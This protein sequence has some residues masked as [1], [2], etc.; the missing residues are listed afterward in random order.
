LRPSVE[1]TTQAK[2]DANHPEGLVQDPQRLTLAQEERRWAREQ[3]LEHISSQAMLTDQDGRVRRTRQAVVEDRRDR[4]PTWE[5]A[6]APTDPREELSRETLATVNQQAERIA[7][8]LDNAPHRAAVSRVLA[9]RVADGQALPE[10]VFET[11]ATCRSR[12]GA[13]SPIADVPEL[14]T[15]TV[16]V[17][18]EITE[19]WPPG[20]GA[21]AWVG[22]IEDDSGQTKVT[23]WEKSRVR[24]VSEGETVRLFDAAVNWYR[25]RWSLA[26]TGDS[27]VEVQSDEG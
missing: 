27:R 17:E 11:M 12:M 18:G 20:D 8:E 4:R 15:Q 25:G 1:Q 21:I 6:E 22:L 3:E 5:H 10:A 24:P 14:D 19:L 2:V 16:T 23:A 9:E 26:L 7:T 13:V